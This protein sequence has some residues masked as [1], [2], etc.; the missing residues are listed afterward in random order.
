MGLWL[1]LAWSYRI[2]PSPPRRNQRSCYYC[3]KGVDRVLA[4][5]TGSE[6]RAFLRTIRYWV[7]EGRSWTGYSEGW[8]VLSTTFPERKVPQPATNWERE[9][10]YEA[11]SEWKL[12]W[13]RCKENQESRNQA[14]EATCKMSIEMYPNKK[15]KQ[16]FVV[17]SIQ[18]VLWN[19]T[20]NSGHGFGEKPWRN[21]EGVWDCLNEI[22]NREN[23]VCGMIRQ[24]G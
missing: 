24:D 10:A 11:Q 18:L 22:R 21:G 9:D 13:N 12:L 4:V 7:I 8:D 17:D 2:A 5:C 6:A 1:I 3:R 19:K 14:K 16:G 15:R 20:I 23:G